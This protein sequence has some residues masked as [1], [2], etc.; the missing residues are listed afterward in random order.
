MESLQPIEQ[1]QEQ[2]QY[3]VINQQDLEI[4]HEIF[5]KLLKTLRGVKVKRPTDFLSK[6]PSDMPE[7]Q[8]MK[9]SFPMPIHSYWQL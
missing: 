3:D 2:A 6:Q 1:E 5:A 7:L 8:S 4:K 9:I